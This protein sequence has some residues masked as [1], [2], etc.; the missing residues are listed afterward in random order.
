MFSEPTEVHPITEADI[1]RDVYGRSEEDFQF[2]FDVSSAE[3]EDALE[4]FKSPVW[5][6]LSVEEQE[7]ARKDLEQRIADKLGVENTPSLEFYEADPHD[8]GAF[9]PDGNC[10]RINKNNFD[11]PQEI[12]DTAAHEI[13]MHIST[14]GR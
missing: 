5:E 6:S 13:G 12:V 11:D 1:Q 14:R 8:C 9:D 7:E 2:D 10:I 3:I 4:K